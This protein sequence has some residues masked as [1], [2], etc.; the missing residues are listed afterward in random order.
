MAWR[1]ERNKKLTD[2]LT[3][4]RE[5]IAWMLA[6]D[7]CT[8]NGFPIY[9]DGERSSWANNCYNKTLNKYTTDELVVLLTRYEEF[10][11]TQS[12]IKNQVDAVVTIGRSTHV[13]PKYLFGDLTPKNIKY[14]RQYFLRVTLKEFAKYFDVSVY[15]AKQWESTP[16]S[17]DNKYTKMLLELM[18]NPHLFHVKLGGR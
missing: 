4:L 14:F 15:A 17:N 2:R 7:F 16:R 10:L 1:K 9:L 11:Q 8:N 12:E 13:P 6:V 5:E 3:V 18:N